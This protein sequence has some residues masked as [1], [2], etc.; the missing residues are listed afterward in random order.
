MLELSEGWGKIPGRKGN[1]MPL[2]V[3]DG[4]ETHNEDN[5]TF[6]LFLSALW[7]QEKESGTRALMCLDTI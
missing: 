6:Q 4:I 7:Y 5:A 2:T 1:F 3:K